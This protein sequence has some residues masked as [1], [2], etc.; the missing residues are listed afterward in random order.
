LVETRDKG[1]ANTKNFCYVN[2]MQNFHLEF[3]RDIIKG[4]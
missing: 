4:L 1:K 3:Y 2:L